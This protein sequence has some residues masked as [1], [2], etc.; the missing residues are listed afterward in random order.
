[1]LARPDGLTRYIN[2][3]PRLSVHLLLGLAALALVIQA[4]AA[5]L[6]NA[7]P[8]GEKYERMGYA[9]AE[10]P[11]LFACDNFAR[12]YWTP[13]WIATIGGCG[14]GIGGCTM[15]PVTAPVQI[16]VQVT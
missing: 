7:G 6:E 8:D 1:M 3:R 14:P 4:F 9:A 5:P 2:R 10:A 13:G 15:P 16:V 11:S 12:A